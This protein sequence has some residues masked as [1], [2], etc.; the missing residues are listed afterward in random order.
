[1]PRESLDAPE[2]LPKQAPRQGA[3]GQLEDVVPG[4]PDQ[5]PAGLEQPLLQARQGP[6]LDGEG[7]G[8]PAQQGA[9]I[10]GNDPAEQPHLVGPE[11]VAGKPRPVGGGFALL[12]P[13]LRRPALVVEVDDGPV[14][15]GQGGDDEAYSGEQLAEMMLDL[16]DHLSRSVP[17]GGLVVETPVTLRSRMKKLGI[18]RPDGQ[19]QSV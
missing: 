12:D 15:P 4:V 17:G 10:V 11:T 7:Q 2:D 5:A 13:L 1:M 3:L 16:G 9:E 18:Q 6:A 8:E 19:V 14:R